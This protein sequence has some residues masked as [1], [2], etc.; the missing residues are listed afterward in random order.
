M[1]RKPIHIDYYINE[2]KIT[3]VPVV[4]DL[5]ILIDDKMTFSP[6]FDKIKSKGTKIL[7]FIKRRAHE[8]DDPYVTKKLYCAFVRP[9]MEYGSVVWNP[10]ELG[11]IA[12]IESIQKQFLLYALRGLG[13]RTDTYSLPSYE[14]RLKLINLETLEF[15]RFKTDVLFAFDLLRRNIF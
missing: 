14:S 2:D 13:W 7:G 9:I 4:T 6:H 10:Y 3:R 12:Q 1:K 11:D 15:R 8:F 5:G